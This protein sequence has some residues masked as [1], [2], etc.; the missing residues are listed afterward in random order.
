M[1]FRDNIY[2]L[3]T[4]EYKEGITDLDRLASFAIVKIF[5]KKMK[6]YIRSYEYPRLTDKQK[7]E[8]YIRQT[9]WDAV[10][11]NVEKLPYYA[12]LLEKHTPKLK[13]VPAEDRELFSFARKPDWGQTLDQEKLSAVKNL[14]AE[15]ERCLSR[16]RACRAFFLIGKRT[17]IWSFWKNTLR[18]RHCRCDLSRKR[19]PVN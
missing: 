1:F 10:T 16:I 8:K 18:G 3:L 4:G 6:N 17:D 5:R 15:Y 19:F 13:P 11:S 2:T 12:Y 14:I 7:K 9:D